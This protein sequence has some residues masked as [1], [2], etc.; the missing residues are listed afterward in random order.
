VLK[1]RA[2]E[3]PPPIQMCDALARN[4]PKG[5]AVML[6]N[7]LAHC[8][9]HYVDVAANFAPEC[10]YVLETLGAVYGYDE[11]ARREGMS[12]I[13]RLVHHQARSGPLQEDLRQW[14]KQRLD[15]HL[16]EPN[17]GLGQAISYM[18]KH[19]EKLALF[20]RRAGAPLDSNIV[21]RTLKKAI[22]AEKECA[23]L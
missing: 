4:V 12:D 7:C 21:E 15:E 13:E 10:Q 8:R 9:R 18:L 3:L 14:G 2:A 19:W 17:S 22:F 5:F 6:G 23:V 1:Q 16:V 20:L 11:E